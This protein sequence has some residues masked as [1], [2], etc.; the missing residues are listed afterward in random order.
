MPWHCSVV[1]M[2]MSA[3]YV[4]RIMRRLATSAQSE[5]VS[6]CLCF[7]I[8]WMLQFGTMCRFCHKTHL[9]Q[10]VFGAAVGV[11]ENKVYLHTALSM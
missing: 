10:G 9:P 4:T 5:H 11:F 2:D 7:R 8:P 6:S 3:R 1:M